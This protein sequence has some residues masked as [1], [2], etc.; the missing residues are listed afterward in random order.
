MD[1]WMDG[2]LYFS[3]LISFNIADFQERRA[4]ICNLKLNYL[5]T[6]V[7]FLLYCFVSAFVPVYFSTC[8]AVQLSYLPSYLAFLPCFPPAFF[9]CVKLI[10]INIL[11]IKFILFSIPYIKNANKWR[12]LL[13]CLPPFAPGVSKY[14]KMLLLV[15]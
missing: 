2:Q 4:D 11:C 8:L 9:S 7:I 13:S 6:W 12:L 3:T 5:A 10:F 15:F 1:R 14:D